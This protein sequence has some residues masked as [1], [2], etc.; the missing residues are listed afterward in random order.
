VPEPEVAA[1]DVVAS[2]NE[3]RDDRVLTLSSEGTQRLTP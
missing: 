2:G 1:D 3:E